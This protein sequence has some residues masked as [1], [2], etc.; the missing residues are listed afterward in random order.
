MKPHVFEIRGQV[1]VFCSVKIEA[2]EES[3]LD[4]QLGHKETIYA[5]H[6]EWANPLLHKSAYGATGLLRTE[7][8]ESSLRSGPHCH[9]YGGRDGDEQ[10]TPTLLCASAESV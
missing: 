1:N 5:T 3:S 8:C 2:Y 4:G 6:E 9:H 10:I 7:E